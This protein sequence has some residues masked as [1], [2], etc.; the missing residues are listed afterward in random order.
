MSAPDA[1]WRLRPAQPEDIAIVLHQRRAMFED[2]GYRDAAALDSMTA[3]A[4]PLLERGLREGFYHG[5][6]VEAAGRIVAGGGVIT[7]EFQPHPRD[8]QARRAFVVN[9]YTEHDWRRRGLARH[10]MKALVDWSRAQGFEA[11][12]LH[13]SDAARPLYAALGFAP[14]NEMRLD[15]RPAVRLDVAPAGRH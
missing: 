13:A 15:L 6:L 9:M 1:A 14:T 7:L 5:L 10:L 4:A 3:C 11:L 12:Y 8:P 2:M